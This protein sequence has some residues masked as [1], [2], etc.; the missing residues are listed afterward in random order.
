[1]PSLAQFFHRDARVLARSGIQEI[2]NFEDEII[3]DSAQQ[4]AG[5]ADGGICT[6][7]VLDAFNHILGGLSKRPS[8]EIEAAGRRYPPYRF[9]VQ[10]PVLGAHSHGGS[11][12][13]QSQGRCQHGKKDRNR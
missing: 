2:Q 10:V 7:N 9:E 13:P 5:A 1:M 4:R 8:I 3:F 6:G 11:C 12:P